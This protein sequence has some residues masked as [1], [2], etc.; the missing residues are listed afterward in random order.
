MKKSGD[1][2]SALQHALTQSVRPERIR[3][4]LDPRFLLLVGAVL[5]LCL[6]VFC[7][8]QSWLIFSEIRGA[9][10]AEHVRQSEVVALD[11]F[12]ADTRQRVIQAVSSDAVTSA[13]TQPGENAKSAAD[14][15][16]QALPELIA[17]DFYRG[18]LSDVLNSDFSKFGY[19]RAATLV[20]AHQFQRAAPLQSRASGQ[21]KRTLVI[22]LPVLRAKEIIAFAYLELP[23]EPLL[24]IFRQPSVA[25]ARIDLRQGD[26]RGDLLLDTIGSRNTPESL[27]DAGMAVAGSLFRIGSVAEEFF[28]VLPHHLWFSLLLTALALGLA[29]FLWMV[30]ADGWDGALERLRGHK[31]AV[32]NAMAE[33]TL[34][35][36][37]SQDAA[38]PAAAT[39]A[40]PKPA[41]K[42]A[43]VDVA[44]DRS[45]F[46]AYDIRGVLGKTLSTASHG[47]SDAPS[48]ARRS[49]AA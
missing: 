46:R 37:M 23:Y 36:A 43:D 20:Q 25:D 35:Q 48:A 30:R 22:A 14:A 19:A 13:L 11:K 10:E 34:A 39:P 29:L 41:P 40:R 6:T 33:P 5:A 49:S 24:Q 31:P 44:V 16:K 12:V 2:P 3:Q 1:K 21:K 4:M 8:W 27:N 38:R 47:R 32:R 26:G 18:D 9:D 42:L 45:I 28:I 17:A 7:T 15:L